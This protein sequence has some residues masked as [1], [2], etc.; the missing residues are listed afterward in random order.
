MKP[1]HWKQGDPLSASRLNDTNSEAARP[2]RQFSLGSGSSMVNETMANQSSS[3]HEPGPMLVM[4]IEDFEQRNIETDIYGI[5]DPQ[6]T[7]KCMM[8]R[9]NSSGAGPSGLYDTTPEGCFASTG[10]E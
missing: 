5:S 8:M 10:N 7:G 9:L 1:K 3:S 6:Y 2:R 4:A